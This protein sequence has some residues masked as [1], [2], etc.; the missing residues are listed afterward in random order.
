MSFLRLFFILQLQVIR[1]LFTINF[2]R[3]ISISLL[4]FCTFVGVDNNESIKVSRSGGAD[5]DGYG[6]GDL[7]VKIKVSLVFLITGSHCWLVVGRD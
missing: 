1:T 4:A 3:A 7:Y 6:P 5:P 2:S